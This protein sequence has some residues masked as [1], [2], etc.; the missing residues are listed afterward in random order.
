LQNKIDSD[1]LVDR[2]WIFYH[3]GREES[4]EFFKFESDGTV[5]IHDHDNERF[6]RL[7][8]GVLEVL[9]VNHCVTI[10]FEDVVWDRGAV[11]LSGVHI[12]SPDIVLFLT[13]KIDRWPRRPGTRSALQAQIDRWGWEIGEHTYGMPGLI[14]EGRSKL[15]IGRFTSI[16][17]GVLLS[18]GDHRIDTVSSYPFIALKNY[19]PSAPLYATDHVSKGDIVIG[20][21][22]WLGTDSFIVSG[23]TIGDG[24]VVAAKC[25][26]TKDIPPYAV[27]AGCPGRIVRF[28]FSETVIQD[29]LR[30][31]WWDWPEEIIDEY[32][33]MIVS[34]DVPAFITKAIC[35]PRLKRE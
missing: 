16:A 14:E 29:L 28:R 27:V 25:V 24:A 10:R 9:D 31:R 22:V 13:E 32:L 30:I 11:R 19:W 35:D 2:N 26:V 23:V 18:F 3:Q 12:P 21:D 6:W 8:D 15:R 33:P 4:P 17:N 5:A 1:Y 7:A 20:N 34:S